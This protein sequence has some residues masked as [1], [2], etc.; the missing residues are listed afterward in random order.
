MQPELM[1]CPLFKY[2][3]IKSITLL[4]SQGFCNENYLIQ[5]AKKRYLLRKFKLEHNRKREFKVQKLA[6]KKHISAK[7]WILDEEKGWMICD[8]VEGRHKEKLTKQDLLQLSKVL[9]KLHKIPLREKAINLK[10][11]FNSQT[12]ETKKAFKILEKYKV[13]NV[14]CHNDLNLKNILFSANKLK[15]IDW[16]FSTVNDKYFDLACICVEAKLNREE[17]TC[18]LA[19]YFDRKDSINR[20]KLEAYKTIYKALC[21][22]WFADL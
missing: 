1:D 12:K 20:A 7:P 15:L 17:E 16:E 8:F 21:L 3:P 4:A 2:D 11:L 5:T 13:E 14:L 10:K 18:F 9:Q 22:Q 6:Y 19:R